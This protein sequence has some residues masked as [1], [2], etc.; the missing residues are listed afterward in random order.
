MESFFFRWYLYINIL[1]GV[2]TLVLAIFFLGIRKPSGESFNAYRTCLR[3]LTMLFLFLGTSS[4][5][6]SFYL[7]FHGGALTLQAFTDDLL[8]GSSVAVILFHV[9]TISLVNC[10]YLKKSHYRPRVALVLGLGTFLV[11]SRLLS[12]SPY[13]QN[14]FHV[15]MIVL[16]TVHLF[17]ATYSVF[18]Q[19]HRAHK[20]MDGFFAG[21]ESNYMMW[22]NITGFLI[23][24]I[25][26]FALAVFLI[27][28]WSLLGSF[29][30][31]LLVF[32]IVL[33][34]RYLNFPQDFQLLAPILANPQDLNVTKN[35]KYENSKLK[36]KDM[37]QLTRALE[38]E[39]QRNSLYKDPEITVA[40][41]ANRIGLSHHQLSELINRNY[42]QNF[43]SYINSLRI[44]DFQE[45]M[46]DNPQ[47]NI[48]ETA[49]EVGF[50]SKTTFNESFRRQLKMSP[51]EWLARS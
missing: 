29:M 37:D 49:L 7:L 33:A 14:T 25:G 4:L 27:P 6:S 51:R 19:N 1:Y 40:M 50:N 41:L 22:I 20:R 24:S 11:L 9:A 23:V 21:P 12:W 5:L 3:F 8:I 26:F 34:I 39:I 45:K 44:Q 18:S 36:D 42:K 48:L 13:L 28:S 17:Y 10:D 38:T 15:L 2:M 47:A 31:Y 43:R 30:V 35:G 46:R 16:Y 32:Q